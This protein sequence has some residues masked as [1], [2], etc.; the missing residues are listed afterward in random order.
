MRFVDEFRDPALAST[1]L[2]RI[3]QLVESPALRNRETIRV[4]EVCGGHTH[5]IFRYGLDQL[6]PDRLEL[7]HGPGCPVCVLPR[8]YIDTAIA[9]AR[10]PDVILASFGDLLRVPGTHMSLQQARAEGADIRTL[11]SPLDALQLARQYPDKIVVFLAIG[12][13]TTMPAT[14]LTLL[15]AEAEQLHNFRM[16]TRHISIIPTLKSLLDD[17]T[18]AVDG[19]IGPGH[20]SMVIGTHP[21]NFIAEHYRKPLVVSGFEPLDILQSLQMVLAQ[22]ATDRARIENQYARVV[23]NAGNRQAQVAISRVFEPCSRSAWRGLGAIMQSGV[24]L[25]PRFAEFDAEHAFGCEASG[26][27]V[28]DSV[29]GSCCGEVLKGKLQPQD[30]PLFAV[31]CT[32]ANPVGALMVSSEG[33]CAACY[34]YR[35]G[36]H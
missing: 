28:D 26:E 19:F 17:P 7:I 16:L 1:I 9:I 35:K 12:F 24:V 15:Q 25:K 2:E 13:E 5:T 30:C 23:H 18:L 3:R 31:Q 36:A 14:A 29:E 8:E 4:M 34:Q 11:Y 22:L 27:G 6:L 10:K 33:A 20:V 32:P 21:Y